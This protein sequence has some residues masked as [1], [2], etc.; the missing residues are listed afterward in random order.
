MKKYG[1]DRQGTDGSVILH[2]CTECRVNKATE[3]HSEYKILIA[4]L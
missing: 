4:F 2:M 3:T 1:S